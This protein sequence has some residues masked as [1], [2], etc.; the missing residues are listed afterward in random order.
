MTPKTNGRVMQGVKKTDG[1]SVDVEA[2]QATDIEVVVPHTVV[3]ARD[4]ADKGEQEAD[5]HFRNRIWAICRHPPHR[6]T[7]G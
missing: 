3:C 6:Y 7:R 1:F 2:L 5:R 4:L